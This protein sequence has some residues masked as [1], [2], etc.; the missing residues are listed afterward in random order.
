MPTS[1]RG[2]GA[3][4]RQGPSF[5]VEELPEHPLYLEP[6]R[7]VL[8]STSRHMKP[9]NFTQ[10]GNRQEIRM[11]GKSQGGSRQGAGLVKKMSAGTVRGKS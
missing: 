8:K 6:Q 1:L 4:I 2:Q 7:P 5:F 3:P 11:R 9:R 10:Q